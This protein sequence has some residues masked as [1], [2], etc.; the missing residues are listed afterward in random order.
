MDNTDNI[1]KSL[2]QYNK[3]S[4]GLFNCTMDKQNCIEILFCH[5]LHLSKHYNK[6][7]HNED[8]INYGFCFFVSFIDIFFPLVGTCLSSMKLRDLTQQKYNIYN[9]NV[10]SDIIIS[11]FF[12]LC[13]LC[14]MHREMNNNGD[15][16]KNI[17]CDKT[18]FLIMA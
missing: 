1:E 5:H 4:S 15:T 13:S 7:K 10:E 9:H 16:I 14:Q 11:A 17:F 2:K 12:P 18:G 3:W 6:I 8:D